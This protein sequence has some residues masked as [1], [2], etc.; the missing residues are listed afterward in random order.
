MNIGETFI[1]S[2]IGG[3]VA[4]FI[5]H[6]FAG[7][8][9][10]NDRIAKIIDTTFFELE[11]RITEARDLALKINSE[12]N[13]NIEK[14]TTV[15]SI[16]HSCNAYMLFLEKQGVRAELRLDNSFA[17]FRRVATG[18]EY[19]GATQT[20]KMAVIKEIDRYYYELILAVRS[21]HVH[22]LSGW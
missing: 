3:L 18:G 15:A 2:V 7:R 16:V 11:K 14:E 1:V 22:L 8:R 9:F 21:A 13:Y 4:S 5:Q 19:S 6:L 12:L 10:K 17:N 20:E